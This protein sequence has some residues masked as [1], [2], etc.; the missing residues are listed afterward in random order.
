MEKEREDHASELLK[1]REEL[2]SSKQKIEDERRGR[3]F[4]RM[5]H[6]EEVDRISQDRS[7]KESELMSQL[8]DKE[9]LIESQHVLLTEQKSSMSIHKDQ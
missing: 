9:S 6:R 7:I 5:R 8:K 1:A 4:E 2:L 3:E